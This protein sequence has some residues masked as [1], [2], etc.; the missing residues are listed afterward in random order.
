MTA[1]DAETLGLSADAKGVAISDVTADSPAEKAGIKR[2]D[3]VLS[4]NG[5]D[6]TTA[7][8]L[9]NIIAQLPPG[10]KVT[11]KLTRGG[12]ELR[13]AVTLGKLDEKPD[14]LL[15]GVRAAPLTDELRSKFRIPAR[16]DGLIITDMDDNSPYADR[17]IANLVITQIDQTEV[18]DLATA[19][20]ALTP[21]GHRLFVYYRGAIRMLVI[22]VK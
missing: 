11:L 20:K 14:E 1:E 15:T 10:T 17:L 16:I 13:I 18:T 9:R 2:G 7:E 19:R 12:K 5:Q 4:I 8:D 6:V 21:G 22:D 3:T